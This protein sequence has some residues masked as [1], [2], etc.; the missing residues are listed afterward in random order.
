M[1]NFTN[2][3]LFNGIVGKIF[4]ILYEK[5]PVETSI[6]YIDLID[7]L[8]DNKVYERT[9]GDGEFVDA[10]VNW[11][12]KAGYVYERGGDIVLSAK[13][14][15]VLRAM[16]ESVD[17]EIPLGEKIIEYSKGMFN[18]GLNHSVKVALGL[19]AKSFLG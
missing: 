3:E 13:G 12:I 9:L 18:E 17:P 19:G 15:E 6:T 14:L 5:F 1:K 16:P 2:I 10:T 7:E 11:L 4:A 8:I